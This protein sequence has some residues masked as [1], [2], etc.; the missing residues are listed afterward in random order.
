LDLSF[1]AID[2]AESSAIGFRVEIVCDRRE[3]G[4]K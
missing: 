3:T 1:N 4:Q 2:T